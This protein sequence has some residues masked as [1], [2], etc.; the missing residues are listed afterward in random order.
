[1]LNKVA[2]NARYYLEK[3]LRLIYLL[4]ADCAHL[5]QCLAWNLEP[6]GLTTA[7]FHS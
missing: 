5:N 6:G 3:T 2:I 1:M 7:D 4:G